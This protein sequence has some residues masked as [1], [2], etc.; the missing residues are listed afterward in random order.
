MRRLRELLPSLPGSVAVFNLIRY[1][2]VTSLLSILAATI[3]L[4]FLYREFAL[5]DLSHL[6]Q[7]HN[8]RLATFITNTIWPEFGPFIGLNTS[9]TADAIR[10]HP[11][12]T[13]LHERIRSITSGTSVLKVKIYTLDG[14]TAYSS[15]AAQIGEDKSRNG[16]YLSARGGTPAT[17]ITHRDKFSAFEDTV[18]D[19]GVLASYLPVRP[20]GTDRIVAVLEVYDD[21][22][23]YLNH[24]RQTQK[25]VILGVLGVLAALYGVLYII[26]RRADRIIKGQAAAQTATE[27]RLQEAH[28]S[29]ETRVRDRTNDLEM[30]IAAERNARA[31]NEQLRMAI[32][33]LNE[34]VALCDA[35]DRIVFVNRRFREINT[36]TESHLD[37]G[38]RYEDHLRAGQALGLYP[39]ASPDA[40][41]WLAMVARRRRHPEGPRE[42]RRGT[43]Y[44]W[45]THQRLPDG[46]MITYSIDITERKTAEEALKRSQASL[47][48]R[49]KALAA[50]TREELFDDLDSAAQKVTETA[51]TLLNVS[52]ASVWLFTEDRL[53]IRTLD[54]FERHSGVH[55]NGLELR[56][57]EFPRYF[58]ALN[59]REV[60]LADDARCDSRTSEFADCYLAPLGITAM[61]DI[62]IILYGELRGVLCH[63]QIGA[64]ATWTPEDRL[65]GSALANLINLA[66]ERR[67]RS[68][69][70]QALRHARDL[71]DAASRTK[72][73]FLANMSHEIRTPMNGVLGMAELLLRTPLEEK[74]QRFA[75]SIHR[76]G[77]ALLGII[78]DILDFSKVE[79]GHLKLAAMP[80]DVREVTG[81]VIELLAGKA[82]EKGVVLSVDI[83]TTVPKRLNGDPLRLR[84]ILTNL[85]GNALKFT[86]QGEV[87]V[88]VE[89]V[90]D[91]RVPASIPDHGE[92]CELRFRVRDTGIGIK[93][94]AKQNLFKVFSQGD[95]STTRKYG[96]TGLGLAISKQLVEMMGGT[97][98]FDSEEGRGSEFW[99]TVRMVIAPDEHASTN[100]IRSATPQHRNADAAL[101]P[102]AGKTRPTGRR[103]LLV[104]DNDINQDIATAM[105]EELG[106]CV[107]I[108]V[109]GIEA[110]SRVRAERFDIILMDCQMPELDG[111]GATASIRRLEDDRAKKA[112]EGSYDSGSS[113]SPTRIPIIALTANAMAGDRERCLAAGMDDYLAKPFSQPVM[114]GMLEKWWRGG[115][116]RGLCDTH[117]QDESPDTEYDVQNLTTSPIDYRALDGI[118]AM[119]RAGAPS[120]VAKVLG[121]YLHAAPGLVATIRQSAN[122]SDMETLERS[123]HTFKSSSTTVGANT[124]AAL[125]RSIEND[126]RH[127]IRPEP[128]RLEELSMLASHV[129]AILHAELERKTVVEPTPAAAY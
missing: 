102:L 5:R 91:A 62:P 78:D 48:E 77:A 10:N 14:R 120:L 65:F 15:E 83:N 125:C 92:P 86:H 118:A 63:E 90:S 42:V 2:S 51:C 94:D 55:S 119:Q 117:G 75:R 4:S 107:V 108:A 60:I 47:L 71:A 16:G 39:D 29:L 88:A 31:A 101:P 50:L 59:T 103:V 11:D 38:H 116:Q 52:R 43:T 104:E 44:Q 89:C 53:A 129:I 7:E 79:A 87:A 73:Q 97:I 30:S 18:S 21:I 24:I 95:G 74:Q 8:E 57:A 34:A 58:A 56:A 28:D 82:R 13:R 85:V 110:V 9:L 67:E 72:S 126:A 114:H 41:A 76:S 61:M 99:F 40:N 33:N 6:G 115:V 27:R 70:E 26:V 81:E 98:G 54:L 112:S 123:A 111:F 20:R 127:H 1:F 80:L 12:T 35:D 36:G 113:A 93:A 22:T 19:R 106:H 68:R 105:L 69:V 121:K 25:T 3:G 32:D 64:A 109:N 46:S 96:G 124:L 122:E 66:L 23:P 45:L 84:Q 100:A 128:A 17:E 49:H 37:P